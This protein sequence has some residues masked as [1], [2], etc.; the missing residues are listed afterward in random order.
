M[1]SV[2]HLPTEIQDE[3]LNKQSLISSSYRWK[4]LAATYLCMFSFAMVFQSIPS[5]LSL[6]ISDL[7]VTHGEAGLLMSL[8]ALPGIFTAICGGLIS[9]RFGMKIVGLVSLMIMVAGTFIVGL[10]STFLQALIGR[11]VSGAGGLTLVVI[12]PQLISRWFL[13]RELSVSMGVFN[14]AMPLGAIVCF[15]LFS[16]L[17]SSQGW[18]TPIWLTT[19]VNVF[20][21]IV[22]LF[23]VKDPLK[24]SEK[25]QQINPKDA[26]KGSYSVWLVGFT[27]MWFN[28]GLISF[29]TFS[30]DY[31]IGKGVPVSYASFLSS[32][33]MMGSLFLS[34]LV[35]IFIHKFGKEEALIGISGVFLMIL[36][37]LIP[38]STHILLVVLISIF[39]SL[40]PASIYS[41]PSKIVDPKNLGYAFGVVTGALN[42]GVL[43]GPYLVGL[44]R[45][46]TGDYACSFYLI[47]LFA[48]LQAVTVVIFKFSRYVKR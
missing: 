35:G 27:W 34:P 33:I 18:R 47:A 3:G 4:I 22:F 24:S 45:D 7:G 9:D 28:A 31:F 30:S 41:L 5:L 15:N 36:I 20:A 16:S 37:S 43:I 1:R 29:I 26:A 12:L 40:V 39:T 42:L 19:I 2:S 44:I 48:L 10:S 17:G 8:F 11:V 14:T 21:F 25:K 23:M 46:F 32:I 6:I 38:F 13:G